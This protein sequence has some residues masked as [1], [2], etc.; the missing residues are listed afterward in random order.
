MV[1]IS[2]VPGFRA[3][4]GQAQYYSEGWKEISSVPWSRKTE[5]LIAQ[6]SFYLLGLY[7]QMKWN[8]HSQ[9]VSTQITL[10]KVLLTLLHSTVWCYPHSQRLYIVNE[11]DIFLEF[12]CFFYDPT[13]VGKLISS[14]RHVWMWELDH[15]EDWA[16]KNWCLPT[17][18]WDKTLESPLNFKEIWAANPKGNQPW[19]FIRRTDVEA[20]ALI[21][22]SCDVKSQLIG[23]DSDAGKDL[24]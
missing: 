4:L 14:S 10:E 7:L 12:S 8:R 2:L 17:V 5:D 18:V 16:P 11:T 21:I 20:E 13:D 6:V 23:K 15:K 19:I 24:W 1:V 22:W 9:S 3:F